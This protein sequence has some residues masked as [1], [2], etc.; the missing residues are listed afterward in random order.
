MELLNATKMQAGYT[1]GMKPDGR[2]LLV[3]VVKG[4]FNIPK[5]GEEATLAEEQM[6]LV[7]ADEFTGEPG[8]SAP[9]YEADFSPFKPKCDVLLNGSAYAPGGKPTRRVEVSV[10]VGSW[11]KSLRVVGDRLWQKRWFMV[12]ASRPQPFAVMPISYDKAFGGVDNSH[13]KESKHKAYMPNPIGVGFHSNLQ[14]K[15]IKG[16]RL[17]NTETLRK[18]I[19][20]PKDK[21]Q[22]MALG[23]IGRGWEP[24]SKLGGTYDQN[25]IDNVF[26]F[27]PSDFQDAYYQA[28]PADQQIGYLKGQE[29]IRL[30]NLTPEGR[31]QFRLPA[32]KIP[33]VFFRKNENKLETTPVIDTLLIEPDLQRFSLTWR[34]HVPLKK[35]M[36]E[37]EQVVAGVM[38]KAWY[39][40][41]ELG[42]TYY[43]SLGELVAA[44][45]P[46]QE[47]E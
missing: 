11:E 7:M 4:T 44:K 38:P 37:V 47:E 12:G 26:P 41:R 45:G 35:N 40:A 13:N 20:K 34:C 16:M 8:F 1:M 3:V 43:R 21:Y 36:F 39:R 32:I 31:T 6:P 28:A 9:I 42:K 18:P 30:T 25:W 19:K 22:P 15:A 2:E 24:R 33:V 14:S 10:Q 29:E 46:G 27:L 17:P 5:N 23:P